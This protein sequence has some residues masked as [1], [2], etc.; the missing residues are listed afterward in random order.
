MGEQMFTMKNEVVGRSSALSDVLVQ[1]VDKKNSE[2]RRFTIS[3]LSCQFPQISRTV[4]YDSIIV[5][6][7]YYK[8]WARWVPKMLM[9]AYKTQRMASADILEP[10]HKDG[11]GFL[12]H[13]VRVTGYETWV[14]FSNIE[15]KDQSKLWMHA[16][17]FSK[18]AEKVSTN[19][20][21]NADGNCFLGQERRA[22]GGIH[23]TGNY[24]IGNVLQSTKKTA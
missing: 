4:L 18:Q 20:C 11:D 15:T 19:V 7:G 22:D 24:N 16:H 14:S 10:Y 8:F 13:T 6:L 9:G 1:S 5:T 17:T 21:Q 23:A 3:K 2:R 12:N